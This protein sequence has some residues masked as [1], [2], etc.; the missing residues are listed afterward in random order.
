[1]IINEGS[2]RTSIPET[3]LS[4]QDPVLADAP[5][6]YQAKELNGGEHRVKRYVLQLEGRDDVLTED[7]GG[8]NHSSGRTRGG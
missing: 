1:V 5:L 4:S 6:E 3:L 2:S 7:L 8:V